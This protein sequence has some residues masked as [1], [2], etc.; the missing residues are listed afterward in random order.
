MKTQRTALILGGGVGGIVVANRLRKH[1]PS[2]DSVVLVD[3][4]SN[5]LFQPS[6]LWLAVGDRTPQDIQRPLSALLRRGVEIVK[7][8]IS[9][10]DPV[11]RR[12]AIGSS[13][14][15]G[16]A[17]IISL[18]VDLVPEMIPGLAEAGHNMYTLDGSIAIQ[19]ALH[20]FRSGRIVVLTASPAY[21]CPAAPYEATMLIEYA[22]RKQRV[23]HNVELALY[24]AEGAPMA[25]A[26]PNVSSAVRQIV[27]T[28]GIEYSPLHQVKDV[29]AR[30]RTLAFT[31]E[32]TTHYDLLIYVP[33]H[34][35]PDVVLKAGLTNE[36]GWIGV[37]RST[38]CT[39]FDEVYA[40]GDITTV[41][42]TMGKPLPKAGVFAHAA[43]EVVAM[44]IVRDWTGRGTAQAFDGRGACFLETGDGKAGLGSG[45][46]YAEPTPNVKLR[47]PSRWWHW[48]KIAFEKRWLRQWP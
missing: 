9:D 11:S 19:E 20:S 48:V 47:A 37:D 27:E 4:E 13:V 14:L 45:N 42:L 40:I 10:I 2:S 24:T 32:S 22:L 30:T 23:R 18:G 36:S 43:G 31:D 8:T 5:H 44:N 15:H 38:F 41:P 1:L 6:L 25:T 34:R 3:R 35:A 39:R 33:P 17:L 28:K 7:G 21:K 29:D 26:G 46:F 16:T 12:V